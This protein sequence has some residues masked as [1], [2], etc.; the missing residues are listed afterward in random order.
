MPEQKHSHALTRLIFLKCLGLIYI[1][2]FASLLPQ[3]VA[4]IGAEGILPANNFLE[5][6]SEKFAQK[7]PIVAP[8]LYWLAPNDGMLIGICVLGIFSAFLLILG[9]VP[10]AALVIAW[11]SYLSLVTIG[12]NFLAFQWDALLLEVGFLAIFFAPANTHHDRFRHKP[13]TLAILWLFRLLLFKLM[14]LSG[15]VKIMSGDAVWKN[16]TALN[17]HYQTQPLPHF[18]SWYAHH[19]PAWF[20]QTSCAAMFFIELVVPFLIFFPR[21]IRFVA[22]G[23]FVLLQ[24]LIILTGNYGF[25]NIL[26]LALCLLLLDDGVFPKALFQRNFETAIPT[27]WIGT[28]WAKTTGVFLAG[29]LIALNVF[30]ALRMAQ[31]KPFLPPVINKTIALIQPFRVC[32]SY[33]LFAVMTKE[34]REIVLE[35]SMDGQT[36]AAY[37]LP[38]QPQDLNVAPKWVAPYQPRLDWQMWFAALGNYQQNPWLIR[39]A[40]LIMKN[41]AKTLALFAHNPFPDTPPKF[42][43]ANIYRYQF[44]APKVRK[45]TGN[46]WSRELLGLY[47]PPLS[48]RMKAS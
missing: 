17:F 20:Q 6:L 26:S 21:K 42:M 39:T 48:L 14:F 1:L 7:A 2:A 15:L 11:V 8:S 23:C 24:S 3:I 47:F 41:D 25:F 19:L 30:I 9:L 33:G 12:Q 36:W 27:P 37:K 34:R 22:A 45:E 43:R 5:L 10:I 40:E 4:L 44:T 28:N 32:N 13:P 16:L 35:G 18:L 29:G 46:W 38:Y 31:I